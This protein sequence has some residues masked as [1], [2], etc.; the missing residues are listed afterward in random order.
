LKEVR[1]VLLYAPGDEHGLAGMR[2]ILQEIG[3]LTDMDDDDQASSWKLLPMVS[4]DL[5]SSDL[6]DILQHALER[7]ERTDWHPDTTNGGVVF[8][9]MDSPVLALADIVTGLSLARQDGSAM[10]CPADD[11]GYGMLCVPESAWNL[12][13]VEGVYWS[14][15][16][17]AISQMKALTDKSIPVI[18]GQLMHDIDEPHDVHRL[19]ERLTAKK[20]K[21][22]TR[23][24]MGLDKNSQLCSDWQDIILSH[25]P[26]CHYSRQALAALGLLEQEDY[27]DISG[28]SR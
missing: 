25:H 14:H 22:T 10:M 20:L 27:G 1:K 26:E 11:G 3:L 18:V 9:G 17:T 19:C 16:L 6:G 7:I 4:P 21:D 5:T 13:I 8:L 15:A 23:R 2:A 24:T 12:S 28:E